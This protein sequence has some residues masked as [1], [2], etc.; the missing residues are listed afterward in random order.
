MSL[1]EKLAELQAVIGVAV[2]AETVGQVG[3]RQYKYADLGTVLDLVVAPM[4]ERGMVIVTT[5]ADR[6][7]LTAIR[8]LESDD[9]IKSAWPLPETDDPQTLGKAVTYGRRYSIVTMLGL[10]AEADTDGFVPDTRKPEAPPPQ[11]DEPQV[12]KYGGLLDKLTTHLVT[13]GSLTPQ[14][15]PDIAKSLIDEWGILKETEIHPMTAPVANAA[16]RDLIGAVRAK[17]VDDLSAYL[18]GN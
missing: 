8:D 13:E 16:W 1:Y 18:E 7:L 10:V 2:K 5:I 6:Q 17:Q 4:R 15:S 12:D 9:T 14:E 11:P 3:T